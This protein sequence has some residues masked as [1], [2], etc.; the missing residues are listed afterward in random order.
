MGSLIFLCRAVRSFS[1]SATRSVSGLPSV[2][3][4]YECR[5]AAK[6]TG[7]NQV[8]QRVRI[9]VLQRGKKLPL[10]ISGSQRE[11]DDSPSQRVLVRLC[12]TRSAAGGY[13]LSSYEDGW[14]TQQL[15]HDPTRILARKF[16]SLVASTLCDPH[17]RL[18]FGICTATICRRCTAPVSQCRSTRGSRGRSASAVG[19][20]SG[21]HRGGSSRMRPHAC[22]SVLSAAG[23]T[24]A[25]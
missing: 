7:L 23:G 8:V 3:V 21:N 5:N 9:S 14:N 2:P 24:L 12:W 19:K 18:L 11:R 13:P 4:F 10:T 16:H 25:E 6:A 20:G 15:A 22:S 1:V 17:S